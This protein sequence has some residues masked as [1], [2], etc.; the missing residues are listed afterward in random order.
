MN[1]GIEDGD[2]V[3]KV[4][5]CKMIM[6]LADAMRIAIAINSASRVTSSWH[7]D[8]TLTFVGAADSVASVLPITPVDRIRWMKDG[9]LAKEKK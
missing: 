3:L 5:E 2:V 4:G 7:K 9:E 8:G 6:N 1:D